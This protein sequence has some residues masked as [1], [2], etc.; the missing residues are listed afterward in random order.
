MRHTSSACRETALGYLARRNHTR[1]ELETKLR[2]KGFGVE[3]IKGVLAALTEKGFVDDARTAAAFVKARSARGVGRMRLKAELGA[4]GVNGA[5]AVEALAALE[6]GDER[7]QLLAALRRK[8]RTLP[9]GLTRGERS[10][11]LFDHLVRR[12]FAPGAVLEALR[13]KGEPSDDDS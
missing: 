13:Q 11:K 12:G 8:E 2:R 3:E 10:K 9:A 1:R 6:P 4:R 7:A 5:G